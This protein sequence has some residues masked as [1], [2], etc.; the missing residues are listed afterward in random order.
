MRRP[1]FLWDF[2]VGSG[3]RGT[4]EIRQQNGK[5]CGPD[6]PL[7]GY[8]Q[9]IRDMR[10]TPGWVAVF[11]HGTKVKLD[12]SLCWALRLVQ[13]DPSAAQPGKS[14]MYAPHSFDRLFIDDIRG[15]QR[16]SSAGWP[17]PAAFS[18]LLGPVKI[19]IDAV[20]AGNLARTR[21]I[22]SG[23]LARVNYPLSREARS[24]TRTRR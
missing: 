7:S 9:D 13:R 2:P 24:S 23:T 19:G 14:G 16:T 20:I 6:A 11:A 18:G 22:A 12:G 5:S 10:K 4:R 3:R 8:L 21:A 1:H 15:R 17:L